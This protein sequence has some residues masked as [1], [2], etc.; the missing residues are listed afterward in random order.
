MNQ[1]HL[2]KPQNEKSH[3]EQTKEKT[4]VKGKATNSK[5][6]DELPRKEKNAKDAPVA[7]KT[8]KPEKERKEKG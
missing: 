1:M 2:S 8:D 4:K 7:N 3:P 6:K 5:M